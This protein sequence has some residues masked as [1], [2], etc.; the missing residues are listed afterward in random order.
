MQRVLR[1]NILSRNQVLRRKRKQLEHDAKV[2]NQQILTAQVRLS[3]YMLDD[4]KAERKARR[5][6]WLLG[7]L[8]PNREVGVV[9]GSFG[10]LEADRQNLPDVRVSKRV[11]YCNFV[12]GD[13]VCVVDGR[14]K[15]KI[16]EVVD[17]DRAT[18][19][20]TVQGLNVVS[21]I[22]FYRHMLHSLLYSCRLLLGS[23]RS[24]S[25]TSSA[26]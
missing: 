6:D 26:N 13:R 7:P 12:S 23:K 8:A 22:S 4:I 1:R 5:E 21:Y 16:G 25:L 19:T 2:E 11:K 24:A 17:V 20:V 18:E 9:K 15:G 14:E 10:A 3:R